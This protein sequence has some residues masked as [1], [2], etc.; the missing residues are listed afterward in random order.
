MTAPYPH[1][2]KSTRAEPP[3]DRSTVVAALLSVFVSPL[4]Y[5]YVGRTRLAVLN[6]LTLNY[7]LLGVLV[8]PVHTHLIVRGANCERPADGSADRTGRQSA[9]AAYLRQ[10]QSAWI[11]SD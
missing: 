2:N 8:V 9:T 10:Y 5:Y 6:L 1:A 11:H 3:A 4:G 7:L